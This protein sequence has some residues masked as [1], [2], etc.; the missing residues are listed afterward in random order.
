LNS[1]CNTGGNGSSTF[2]SSTGAATGV[3]TGAATGALT[4]AT[5]LIGASSFTSGIGYGFTSA[6]AIDSYFGGSTLDA[7]IYSSTYLVS[8]FS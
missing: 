6:K 7:L 5:A 3:L 1:V 4:G 2:T 8:L